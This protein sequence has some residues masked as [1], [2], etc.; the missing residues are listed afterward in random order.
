MELGRQHC[1]TSL[2]TAIASFI[3]YCEVAKETGPIFIPQTAC[4][5]VQYDITPAP[6]HW[7]M[8]SFLGA[9]HA[10][11]KGR[12]EQGGGGGGKKHLT[13]ILV[14]ISPLEAPVTMIKHIVD[15]KQTRN[16]P[17]CKT[18]NIPSS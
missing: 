6:P 1:G 17:G 16:N 14:M 5:T 18:H 10:T 12:R 3:G 4:P 2:G 13:R 9:K 7:P 11:R 15:Y 8:K